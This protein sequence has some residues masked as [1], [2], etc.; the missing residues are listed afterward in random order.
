MN[1]NKETILHIACRSIRCLP[2][3]IELLLDMPGIKT[4]LKNESGKYAYDI[5]LRTI[6]SNKYPRTICADILHRLCPEEAIQV[7]QM[8]AK[9]NNERTNSDDPDFSLTRKRKGVILTSYKRHKRAKG[10]DESREN[11][12]SSKES[13]N[14]MSLR[15]KTKRFSEYP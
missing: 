12:R 10:D 7:D 2:N 8:I 1:N 5:M 11:I 13:L 4:Y 14:C 3:I 6:S 9:V 15:E